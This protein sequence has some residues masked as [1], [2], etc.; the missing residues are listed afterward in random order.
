[1]TSSIQK[2]LHQLFSTK[3]DLKISAIGGG[4]I[5]ET[6]SVSASSQ[7]FFLKINSVTQYPGL[8][9]KEKNGLE[10]LKKQNAIYTPSVVAYKII[11]DK[12]ILLLEWI[13]TGL[14]TEE[15]WKRFGEQLAFLHQSTWSDGQTGFGFEEDNYM[16]SLPQLNKPN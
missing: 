10:F 5:N 9:E 8:F 14:K 2:Y 3:T 12:Q 6:F 4:C 11:E 13:E 1:M 15:F 16:G 7:P